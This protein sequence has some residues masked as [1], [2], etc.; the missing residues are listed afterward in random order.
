[1]F[2]KKLLESSKNAQDFANKSGLP[3]W[4]AYRIMRKHAPEIL[5]SKYKTTDKIKELIKEGKSVEEIISIVGL[6]PQHTRNQFHKL[7]IPINGKGSGGQNAKVKYNP[8]TDSIESQYWIGFILADGHIS[9]HKYSIRIS[10]KELDSDII[11]KFD[12]FVGTVLSK[13]KTYYTIKSGERRMMLCANLGNKETHSYFKSIGFT[14]NKGKTMDLKIPLTWAIIAGWFDGDGH[15]SLKPN[16]V[17]ITTGSYKMVAKLMSF[18]YKEKLQAYVLPK[19]TA[20]DVILRPN[21]RVIF[22]E[23]INSLNIPRLTRKY[24]ALASLIEISG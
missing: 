9:K 11:Y 16:Q 15:I 4:K 17:K 19:G 20:F 23:N 2:N 8:F 10:Q 3:Y 7:K 22:A 5:K 1:M 18:F 24:K 13:T 6:S 12:D 14:S 21:S